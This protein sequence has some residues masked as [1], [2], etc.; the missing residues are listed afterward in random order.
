MDD[1]CSSVTRNTS[2][3]RTSSSHSLLDQWW[4]KGAGA[5]V[6]IAGLATGVV[7]TS[8]EASGRVNA[9]AI[10]IVLVGA[11]L[12]SI[13]LLSPGY[14]DNL[15]WPTLGVGATLVV[16]A[17]FGPAFWPTSGSESAVQS[18]GTTTASSAPTTTP[19]PGTTTALSSTTSVRS[20]TSTS[21][22][23]LSVAELARE[24][25]LDFSRLG[26]GSQRE[27]FREALGVP[28]YSLNLPSADLTETV[29]ATDYL[30]V[31][32]ITDAQD[33][34]QM[35]AITSCVGGDVLGVG[36]STLADLGGTPHHYF[37]SGATSNSYIFDLTPGS[38]PTN[39]Q[40]VYY[41]INDACSTEEDFGCPESIDFLAIQVAA[42]V[43]PDSSDRED[44][45]RLRS[46]SR[47]NTWAITAP[48]SQPIPLL[49]DCAPYDDPEMRC[50]DIGPDR[51]RV[52]V[53]PGPGG[54]D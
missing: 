28:L 36:D 31:Q 41:G 50:F 43:V 46:C 18:T 53:L 10:A 39:Y 12:G 22:T 49:D 15:R 30:Y 4:A 1:Y 26:A 8:S 23:Q 44:I 13:G 11:G 3:P 9:T 45:D 7:G 42:G 40:D 27:A 17:S 35:L 47:P 16:V 29:W 37:I 2:D 51:I 48:Q 20:P 19:R 54:T 32:A 38:N 5:T 24:E 25:F 34:V 52:R 33:T 6:G 14:P 21:T